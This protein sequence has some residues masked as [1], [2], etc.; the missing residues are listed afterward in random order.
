MG[1]EILAKERFNFIYAKNAD[2]GSQRLEYLFG[3]R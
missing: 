2:L 3:V 1:K